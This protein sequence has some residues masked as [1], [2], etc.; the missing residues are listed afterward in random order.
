MKARCLKCGGEHV[1]QQ[2]DK[3]FY[4]NDQGKITNP[5]CINC[6]KEEHLAP[7]RGC[8]KFNPKAKTNLKTNFFP[9]RPVDPFMTYAAM[10]S[11]SISLPDCEQNLNSI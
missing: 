10:A 11:D 6:L 7:W 2:C 9:S 1:H 8:E 3:T 5:K 4:L